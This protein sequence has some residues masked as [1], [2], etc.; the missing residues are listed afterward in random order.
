MGLW[1]RWIDELT[2]A[3]NTGWLVG[4]AAATVGVLALTHI[5]Q[6]SMP[7][8][9]LTDRFDKLEHVAAYGMIA[10]LYMLALRRQPRDGVGEERNGRRRQWEIKGWLGLA[11]LVALG[12][13]AIGAVD[14][15]TQPFVHRTC[16]V[17]DWTADAVGITGACALFF[18]KRTIIG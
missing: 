7:Q 9:L 18:V 11:V 17:W 10:T 2:G 16:S 5:P 15:W 6:D 3:F 4:A 14:E 1:R 12:L 13:A 8:V